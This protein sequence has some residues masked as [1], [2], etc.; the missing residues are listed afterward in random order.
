MNTTPVAPAA[1]RLD[2]RR[3][4]AHTALVVLGWLL[5]AWSWH[6]V[7]VNGPE[8]GELR[9]LLLSALLVVPVLTLSWV[10]HN[11]GIHRRKGPR[12][13]VPAVTTR[14]DHDFNGR[15][16]EA[17]WSALATARRIDILVEGDRKRFVASPPPPPL[18][19]PG[20]APAPAP[21]MPEE[22]PA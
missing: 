5:F 1:Q 17:D 18:P 6:R 9:W 10:A 14:H 22:E 7:T 12:R 15:R 8:V 4:I 13:S 16:L 21:R 20:V 19:A 3:R 2:A 11:V